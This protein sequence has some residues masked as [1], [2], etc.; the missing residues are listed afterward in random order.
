LNAIQPEPAKDRPK[1]KV[2]SMQRQKVT[3]ELLLEGSRSFD[4]VPR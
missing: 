2:V 4:K 3:A 1:G